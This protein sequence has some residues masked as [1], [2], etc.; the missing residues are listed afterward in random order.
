ME[1]YFTVAGLVLVITLFGW[2][3]S[4][5]K[6]GY[7]L[8]VNQ[9]WAGKALRYRITD[10]GENWVTVEWSGSAFS[11]QKYF[12]RSEFHD[13]LRTEGCKLVEPE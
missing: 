13:R 4:R 5:L 10:I 8:Q 11:G 6:S 1:L 3:I 7:D 2:V 9:V 12:L